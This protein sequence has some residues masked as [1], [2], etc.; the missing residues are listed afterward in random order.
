[1]LASV[2]LVSFTVIG[3][4]VKR[5]VS[6]AVVLLR[7]LVVAVLVV[8]RRLSTLGVARIAV[9]VFVINLIIAVVRLVVR[10]VM[11]AVRVRSPLVV[12]EVTFPVAVGWSHM[13][14]VAEVETVL[15]SIARSVIT[16][17]GNTTVN[18]GINNTVLI[19]CHVV[20]RCKVRGSIS[21][22]ICG[23]S[24]SQRCN[25]CGNLRRMVSNGSGH[26][27]SWGSPWVNSGG[28]TTEC[29]VVRGSIGRTTVST[30][31]CVRSVSEPGITLG[32]VVIGS[33]VLSLESSLGGVLSSVVRCTHLLGGHKGFIPTVL[34]SGVGIM[35]SIEVNLRVLVVRLHVVAHLPVL[36]GHVGN[37]G[38]IDTLNSLAG[39]GIS[40][41]VAVLVSN[42]LT[43]V[44]TAI[45]VSH[46]AINAT[47]SV[48][49]GAIGSVTHALVVA[50]KVTEARGVLVVSDDSALVR[51]GSDSLAEVSVADGAA[52]LVL[53]GNRVVL[54]VVV[55]AVLVLVSG[56]SVLTLPV[57][58]LNI[59]V[60]S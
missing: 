26:V 44:T 57:T 11:D 4:V 52:H 43:K 39:I 12:G 53:S 49:V 56:V 58:V 42:M 40:A 6:H 38:L 21:G 10:C 27:M 55:R 37:S 48:A 60:G 19:R 23:V 45:G 5:V 17:T 15:N 31:G 28:S 35:V 3:L 7:L 50:G 34:R 33:A 24:V 54:G 59:L 1:M 32:N 46:I 29:R 9:I 47:M 30:A 18:D 13:I 2:R 22:G 8:L 20:N 14:A 41:H 51:A 16:V 36:A 25:D